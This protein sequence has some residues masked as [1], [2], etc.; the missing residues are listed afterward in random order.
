[1]K[2][3]FDFTGFKMILDHANAMLNVNAKRYAKH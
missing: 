2:P 1:M 3:Q